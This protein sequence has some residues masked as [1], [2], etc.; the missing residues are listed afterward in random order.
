MQDF[1]I[2]DYNITVEE[3]KRIQTEVSN[4]SVIINGEYYTLI[5]ATEEKHKK[6]RTGND[7]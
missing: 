6:G 5:P 2:C 4:I 3:L 7:R 1:S